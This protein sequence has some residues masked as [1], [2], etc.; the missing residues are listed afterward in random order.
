MTTHEFVVGFNDLAV[1]CI[2]G[3]LDHE[4]TVEQPV[5]VDVEARVT[6]AREAVEADDASSL[7]VDYSTLARRCRETIVTGRFG[8]LETMA[9]RVGED[10]L[11]AHAPYMTAV[12]VRVRKPRALLD[13]EALVEI[14]LSAADLAPQN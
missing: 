3:I 11:R 12:R 8:L 2:V 7:S 5:R 9:M 4:R 14:S 1:N 10:L 13:A 6:Y